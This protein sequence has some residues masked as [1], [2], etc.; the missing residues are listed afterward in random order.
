MRLSKDLQVYDPDSKSIWDVIAV[1]FEPVD[2]R[3]LDPACS[4]ETIIIPG[5]IS[6]DKNGTIKHFP[7]DHHQYFMEK[8]AFQDKNDNPIRIGHV[9]EFRLG[10]MVKIGA[11]INESRVQWFTKK[12]GDFLVSPQHDYLSL[13]AS[14]SEIKGVVWDYIS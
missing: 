9:L 7:W 8:T 6:K 3:D 10:D 1:I 5:I 11:V 14:S 2:V 4:S 13:V 12:N